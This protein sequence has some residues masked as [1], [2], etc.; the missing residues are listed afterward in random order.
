MNLGDIS[1]EDDDDVPGGRPVFADDSE[2]SFRA[3]ELSGMDTKN[4]K[5]TSLRESSELPNPFAFGNNHIMVNA[6]R[7]LRGLVPFQRSSVLNDLAN[8]RATLLAK[9]QCLEP[10]NR[11]R[12]KWLLS[13]KS[14]AENI[15]RGPDATTIHGLCMNEY[16]GHKRNIISQRFNEFGMGTAIGSDGDIY[17]VQYFRKN[18]DLQGADLLGESQTID[19]TEAN[20]ERDTELSEF[21]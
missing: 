8:D 10:Q 11:M 3:D 21:E 17:L 7:Q 14:A 18:T 15:A 13:C 6:E 19:D 9:Q 16:P 2:V 12:L 20:T 1:G 5:D 4:K